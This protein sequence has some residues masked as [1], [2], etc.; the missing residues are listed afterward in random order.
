MILRRSLALPLLLLFLVLL[1]GC[2]GAP[3]PE[4]GAN[5]TATRITELATREEA[6]GT[7]VVLKADGPLPYK[8]FTKNDPPR[9]LLSFPGI[10]IDNAIQPR[11]VN[12]A[13][14]VGLFPLENDARQGELELTL[15][16]PLEYT[17][18]ENPNGLE[19]T[20]LAAQPAKTTGRPTIREARVNRVTDGSEIRFIGNGTL[21]DPMVLRSS[22]PPRMV[23]DLP[24]VTGPAEGRPLAGTS[25]EVTGGQLVAAPGKTRLIVDLADPGIAY[26]INR[27]RESLVIH[28]THR[29]D[30]AGTA[31]IEDVHFSRANDDALTRI[32]L[33]REGSASS[34]MRQGNDLI[35]TLKK[36]SA[37]PQWIRRMD[38]RDFGAPIDFVDLAPDGENLRATL[39]LN[40]QAGQ[41]TIVQKDREILI[42]VK[43]AV[44]RGET[45]DQEIFPYSGQKVS[46]DV[47]DIDIQNALRFM[48]E[49]AKINII[50]SDAVTGTL[51]MHISDV[52]WDQAL[53]L[54]LEAKGLGKI[55][56]GNVLR[57]APRADLQKST[58][59]RI[60]EQNSHKQLEPVVTEMIPVSFS[61]SDKIK[62]LLLEGD[63]AKGTRLLSSQG[64][65]SLD[66]RTNTLIVKDVAS[67]L[68]QIRDMVK[69]LDQPTPQV[70]IEARIVEVERRESESL[71]INWG[72]AFKANNSLGIAGNARDAYYSQRFQ[73]G[74][75]TASTD[76]A[77]NTAAVPVENQ[78]FNRP[79][80]ALPSSVSM[81]PPGVQPN[82]GIH[83][84]SINPLLDLDIELGALE[85]ANKLRNIASPRL[86]TVNNQEA[87]ITQGITRQFLSGINQQTALPIYTAVKANL[88][89]TVKPQVTPS[90]H[91][92]LKLTAKKDSFGEAEGG[93]PPVSTKMIE[94]QALV[95][96]GETIVL[97]GI[98]ENTD[99]S[100]QHGIPGLS[101]LPLLGWLFKDKTTSSVQTELLIFLTPRIIEQ[102][103]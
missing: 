56:Q 92:T 98:Y 64:T 57:I 66:E 22:D 28:L 39:R 47:K 44:A 95:Q 40:A 23:L 72:F 59:A 13:T 45:T 70:L 9:I 11:V 36:T 41:H 34:G 55:R 12:L 42:R 18:Q 93:L 77:Y 80:M 58:E 20:V 52:P 17:L 15:P 62:A 2:P 73:T 79:R 26:R 38:V 4:T 27:E 51:T 31:A 84:G 29:P 67:N 21:P 49:I 91:I 86:M 88:E 61:Q 3:S 35:V 50:L 94:T 25:P 5:P 96:N 30:V 101:R 85:S 74:T 87:K 89:L 68:A 14:I 65:V 76:A 8:V 90:N 97:G 43:P 48:A 82:L 83:L 78:F 19:L 81:M 54:M 103:P 69:K 10:R 75:I 46:L 33:D 24:E 7:T 102:K 71:G 60:A 37:A 16:Q 6:R 1:P 99:A 32:R 53:D 63:Q 100:L